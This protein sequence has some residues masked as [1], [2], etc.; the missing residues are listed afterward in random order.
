MTKVA[1]FSFFAFLLVAYAVTS[2]DTKSSVSGETYADAYLKCKYS[3]NTKYNVH[4]YQKQYPNLSYDQIAHII[5][6]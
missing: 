4:L 2:N 3:D 5:C 1:T 6:K